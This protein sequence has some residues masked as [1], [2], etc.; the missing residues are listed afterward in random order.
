MGV[1]T[2]A[3][4][5]DWRVELGMYIAGIQNDPSQER[6]DIINSI[7][8]KHFEPNCKKLCWKKYRYIAI[9]PPTDNRWQ[10]YKGPKVIIAA[11]ES[12]FT[13]RGWRTYVYKWIGPVGR[14]E[15]RAQWHKEARSQENPVLST[16]YKFS[17]FKIFLLPEEVWQV[18]WD[19][20]PKKPD[21]FD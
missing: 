2:N 15:R 5:D 17:D 11:D 8:S 13:G 1:L 18:L 16:G 3:Y 14:K 7:C 9:A 19:M 4:D 12:L 10:N 6:F 21:E 20:L